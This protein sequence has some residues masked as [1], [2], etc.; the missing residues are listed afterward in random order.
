LDIL[1]A[2]VIKEYR[3]M[4]T[5]EDNSKVLISHKILISAFAL[6]CLCMYIL[7]NEVDELL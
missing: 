6:N 5:A 2:D 4:A 7:V 1:N 3:M